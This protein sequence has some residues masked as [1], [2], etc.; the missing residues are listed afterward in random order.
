VT[1]ISDSFSSC[2]MRFLLACTHSTPSVLRVPLR[3]LD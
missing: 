1:S 3:R 2:E